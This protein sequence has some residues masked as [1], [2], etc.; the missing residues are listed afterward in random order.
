[1]DDDKITTHP[2]YGSIAIHRCQGTMVLYDSPIPHHH[3]ITITITHAEDH[4]G[5]H[6]NRHHPT[7]HILEVSM[8]EAQFAQAITS[9]NTVG[10][11]CTLTRMWDRKTDKYEMVERLKLVRP[12]RA[13]FEAEV[14]EATAKVHKQVKA[15][16]D[17]LDEIM[18]RT[19]TV[20]KS[21]LKELESL[22]YH[23]EQDVH[24]N[25]PFI[26]NS[27]Y[28]AMEG[29]AS[30]IKTEIVATAEAVMRQRGLE[31][32]E[33]ASAEALRQIGVGMEDDE[34]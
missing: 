29:V 15:A 8:S 31:M 23:A 24:L 11:P 14:K 25:L 2:A 22:L 6:H 7:G 16:K 4:R 10:T 17:K 27:F 19:G 5:L 26:Q 33:L 18:Q 12:D 3:Y 9:M 1:M 34:D 13:T 20:K 28:E 30:K 32:T 21:D